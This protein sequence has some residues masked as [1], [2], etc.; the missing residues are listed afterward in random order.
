VDAGRL[1][2]VIRC[3]KAILDADETGEYGESPSG[4][5]D[6]DRK[7]ADI[8]NITMR[9]QTCIATLLQ[10][11]P[12]STYPIVPLSRL[13]V[14]LSTI[15]PITTLSALASVLQHLDYAI[16]GAKAVY[17]PHHPTLAVLAAQKARLLGIEVVQEDRVPN[18]Q[19]LLMRG[20][21]AEDMMLLQ[22]MGITGEAARL[23]CAVEAYREAIQRCRGCFGADGGVL[24]K[25]LGSELEVV[26]RELAIM[27]GNG[28]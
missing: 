24:G 17:T 15:K 13:F 19:M 28:R 3:G 21:S 18:V 22:S 5:A 8:P 6:I 7:T 20:V 4:G 10:I 1:R 16:A 11:C 12:P 9:I 23:R 25:G 27:L 26:E 2:E 14:R